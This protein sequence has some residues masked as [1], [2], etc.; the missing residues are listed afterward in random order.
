M[1]M[2]RKLT[3]R[4]ALLPREEPP[5]MV[6]PTDDEITPVPS[7]GEL[8]SMP[9][10]ERWDVVSSVLQSMR[11]EIRQEGKATREAF[12][13]LSQQ[14]GNLAASD[15]TNAKTTGA[16]A[17]EVARLADADKQLA[18]RIGRTAATSAVIKT[19]GGAMGLGIAGLAAHDPAAVVDFIRT[20]LGG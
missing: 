5:T 8:L 6:P 13:E 19:L 15:A 3:P 7:G 9:E 12:G 10:R 20:V 1:S 18:D 16:H 11:S 17:I 2:G 4:L 14:I